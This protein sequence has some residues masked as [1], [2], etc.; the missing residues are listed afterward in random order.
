MKYDTKEA[1]PNL[2]AAA[3]TIIKARF[4]ELALVIDAVS[5]ERQAL[6]DEINRRV[7]RVSI[8]DRFGSLTPADKAVLR[9]VVNDPNF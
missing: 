5:T 6:S 4:R 1:I 8:K 9:D 3:I 7:S 2:P